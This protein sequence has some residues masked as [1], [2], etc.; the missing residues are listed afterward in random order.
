MGFKMRSG[1]RT[2]FKDLGSSKSSFKQEDPTYAPGQEPVYGI[3]EYGDKYLK[4]KEGAIKPKNWEG[5]K[6][7]DE[8]HKMEVKGPYE[9]RYKKDLTVPEG[10]E[11]GSYVKTPGK[12]GWAFETGGDYDKGYGGHIEHRKVDLADKGYKNIDVRM[13]HQMGVDA[14]PDHRRGKGAYR[15]ETMTSG[16]SD[17]FTRRVR[18]DREH[19]HN[20]NPYT[21]EFAGGKTQ[22]SHARPV[23]FNEATGKYEPVINIDE[24]QFASTDKHRLG[25]ISKG[26]QTKNI[27]GRKTT[28]GDV[29][30]YV[31]D[32]REKYVEAEGGNKLKA[33]QVTDDNK[34][35]V[36]KTKMDDEGMITD[37]SAEGWFNLKNRKR[38]ENDQEVPAWF[39]GREVKKYKEKR[40]A[41]KD[42]KN[43][44]KESKTTNNN[45]Q[46]ESKPKDKKKF[47]LFKKDPNKKK[48]EKAPKVKKQKTKK[49]K[50]GKKPKFMEEILGPKSGPRM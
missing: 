49:N 18:T 19:S 30:H 10:S 7:R 24:G 42:Q 47:N 37:K 29:S 44:L 36:L 27:G 20:Y 9:E 25:G 45:K 12:S 11:D 31:G 41:K 23:E 38:F 21:T 32:G 8:Y 33:V 34:R 4:E 40:K 50:G 15:Y 48:K 6:E 1:K 28:K 26:G 13:G 46:K 3:D 14:G 16:D 22:L 5:R 43:K 35:R 17:Q 39:G 2:N